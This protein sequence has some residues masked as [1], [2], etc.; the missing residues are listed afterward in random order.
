MPDVPSWVNI[1]ITVAAVLAALAVIARTLRR[2][3]RAV[4][5]AGWILDQLVANPE[6]G[7]PSAIDRLV[8]RPATTA[9]PAVPSIF[10]TVDS[11]AAQ[12]HPNHGSSMA[13]N[14]AAVR[15][16]LDQH[17]ALP[18]GRAHGGGDQS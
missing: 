14:V 17:I 3:W 1:V 2:M 4:R 6:T 15:G 8:G 16:M 12:V 7:Q 10:A 18:A 9:L 13:D 5:R 11:I